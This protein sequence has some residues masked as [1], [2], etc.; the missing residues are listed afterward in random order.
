[1]SRFVR[2]ALAANATFAALQAAVAQNYGIML[3]RRRRAGAGWAPWGRSRWLPCRP[4][5]PCCRQAQPCRLAPAR[6]RCHWPAP[7]ATTSTAPQTSQRAVAVIPTNMVTSPATALLGELGLP[8]V[9]ATGNTI[10][11]RSITLANPDVLDQFVDH[12]L[13]RHRFTGVRKR[14]L[15]ASVQRRLNGFDF[16]Y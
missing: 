4:R 14:D 16:K 11:I 1:M 9:N 10:V 15:A 12:H 3:V 13:R 5:R 8:F 6:C 7:F 2:S